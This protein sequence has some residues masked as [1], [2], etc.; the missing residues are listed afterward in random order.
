[1]FELNVSLTFASVWTMTFMSL[2]LYLILILSI[3]IYLIPCL[4]SFTSPYSFTK[5]SNFTLLSSYDLK[6]TLLSPLLI[7]FFVNWL[8]SSPVFSCW[9]GH[10]IVS[11]LQYRMVYF[12]SFFFL[13][14][15]SVYASSFYYNSQDIFDFTTVSY[16]F[17]FWLMLL[18][19]TSNVFTFIFFIE[20]LSVLTTLLLITSTFSSTYFYNNSSFT[21]S[22]Y[23]NQ[24]TPSAFLKTLMFFFWIS[25]VSSLNLFFFLTLTYIKFM[26][27]DWFLLESIFYYVVSV[28]SIK[29]M[30][31]IT[32]SWFTLLFCLF[33]KCGLVPFY[34]WK[35]SFFKGMPL[36]TLFFY[37]CFFY[38]FVFM[39]FV[40]FLIVYFNELFFF[41]TSVNILM[42]LLGSILLVFI[43]CESYYIKAFLAMSSIL[44]TLFIFLAMT[45][46]D[47][48]DLFFIL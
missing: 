17:M 30:F 16:N 47:S 26:T 11:S 22:S 45:S 14:M 28:S 48:V 12:V 35:P 41:S 19:T 23:F 3:I 37:I 36:H 24:T 18:F 32:L 6:L 29:S 13:I 46:F 8:W 27:F 15:W 1:M 9:F 38:F 42:L 40:Y 4:K 2:F 20:L 33:I 10:M 34:F 31:C 7:I 5:H 43:L 21:M 44:N 25:L 39:F